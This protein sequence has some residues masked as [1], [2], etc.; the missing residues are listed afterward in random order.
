M[1]LKDDKQQNIQMEL[2]FSS[3]PTREAREAGGEEIESSGVTNG[4]ENP[5]S[6]NRL[7][8]AVWERENLKAALRQVRANMGSPGVDGVTVVGIKDYLKE[9]WPAIREQL[10]NGTYEPKS[11]RRVDFPKPDRGVQKLG[12]PTVLDRFIQ[13]AVMQVLQRRWDRTFS[14]HSY[15]FRP[16]RSA[17]QAVAQAPCIAKIR[18]IC[19]RRAPIDRSTAMS[20]C[21]ASTIRESVPRILNALTS[22]I[23]PTII[24]VTGSWKA[25]L[26]AREMTSAITLA[27]TPIM[28]STAI[29]EITFSFRRAE[30]ATSD[31]H[32]E[33]ER[34]NG[35]LYLR[36]I[37]AST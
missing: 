8:E 13:Q 31:E 28:A 35:T 3:E 25:L 12:I 7:M 36:E 9:H 4:T 24:H 37:A 11:V 19:E 14:E 33:S 2:D 26:T 22:S 21:L 29:T 23:S 18:W 30:V 16:R 6:T 1:S 20:F 15:G 10:L 5:A 27:A 34:H 32:F 17:H